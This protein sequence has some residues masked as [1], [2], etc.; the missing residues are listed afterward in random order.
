MIDMGKDSARLYVIIGSIMLTLCCIALIFFN[1]LP[2]IMLSVGSL[3]FASLVI[4]SVGIYN[5]K[6]INIY[7]DKENNKEKE[8]EAAMALSLLPGLGHKYLTGQLKI[9]H[10]IV[11]TISI[12]LIITGIM[13]ISGAIKI[14]EG[15]GW[16]SLVYGLVI[17][18]FSWSW[19]ALEVNDIC[20]NMN[21]QNI[22]GIFSMNWDK[23]K[24]GLSILFI[25]TFIILAGVSITW[26]YFYTQYLYEA[27]VAALASTLLL[28]WLIIKIVR[29]D[30]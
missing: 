15:A 9:S 18:F 28:V 30:K 2:G 11:F 27:V 8:R 19:S 26:G 21:L 29:K 10:T 1:D 23:T 16:I 5:I 4:C 12:I 17:F 25:I 3:A 20:N 6:N 7:E 22:K 13:I 24:L 14:E